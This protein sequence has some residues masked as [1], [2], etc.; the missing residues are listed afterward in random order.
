MTVDD[1]RKA[2]VWGKNVQGGES[3]GGWRQGD[4]RQDASVFKSGKNKRTVSIQTLLLS[5]HESKL[6]DIYKSVSKLSE[7]NSH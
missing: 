3:S 5:R 6:I 2:K 7:L 1:H 4:Q